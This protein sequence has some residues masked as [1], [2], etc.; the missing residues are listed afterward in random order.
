M[1]LYLHGRPETNDARNDIMTHN[2]AGEEG[3]EPIAKEIPDRLWEIFTSP[4]AP[5]DRTDL[6]L[7]P[8]SYVFPACLFAILEP[9][10]HFQQSLAYIDLSQY[11]GHCQRSGQTTRHRQTGC[12]KCAL[13]SL[14][15]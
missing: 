11:D 2:E 15:V 4:F 5:K 8:L 14:G 7:L 10:G 9:Q 1:P 3:R 13:T 12:S 6:L